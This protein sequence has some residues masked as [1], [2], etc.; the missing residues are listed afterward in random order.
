MTLEAAVD[1]THD[2]VRVLIADDEPLFVEMVAALLADE[3]RIEIVGKA[4]NGREAV[5]LAHE[6][7][8]DVTLMDISMPVL[9]GIEAT[10][11]IRQQ[12]PDAC[13]LMLTGSNVTA[14]ID[15]SRQAGAAG[16][17]T[18]DRVGSQLVATILGIAR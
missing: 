5:E 12:D 10:R 11:Q 18:K 8:P 3:K 15:R 13:V 14:E 9:D 2:P 6:L 17:M 16:Y 4:R 7:S 1:P